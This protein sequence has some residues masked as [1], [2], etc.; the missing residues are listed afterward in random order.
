LP[1]FRA[2]IAAIVPFLH[3]RLEE[4]HDWNDIKLLT[5]TVDRLRRWYRPGL[6]CIGD[7]AHAMSPIGGVGIN[8]AIQDAV[9]AANILSGPLA[10]GR[11]GEG[12]LARVQRRR[13]WPTRMTQ[14]M[15]L[16]AQNTFLKKTLEGRALKGLPWALTLLRRWPVLRRIPARVVGIGLRP[17]HIN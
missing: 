3:D 15:Q 2:S 13:E 8:L 4:L 11:C 7:A 9:A 10:A 12:D 14:W 17:E 5:V 6:L 1:A 16:I